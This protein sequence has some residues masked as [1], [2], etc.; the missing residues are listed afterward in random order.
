MA[1]NYLNF[2]NDNT[3]WG[4]PSDYINKQEHENLKNIKMELI[5]RF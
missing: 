3:A 4:M 5:E 2:I 1:L